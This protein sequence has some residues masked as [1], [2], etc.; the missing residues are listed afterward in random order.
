VDLRHERRHRHG[1]RVEAGPPVERIV[2][3]LDCVLDA[4]TL[5]GSLAERAR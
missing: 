3:Q 2:E 1:A 5:D 4:F